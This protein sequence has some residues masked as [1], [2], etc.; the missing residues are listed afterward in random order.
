MDKM[1]TCFF[2]GHRKIADNKI[3]DIKKKLTDNIET[4]ITNQDIENFISG[5]ALGFDTMAAEAVIEL[6]SKY[7]HIKLIIYVPCYGQSSKWTS[8]QK[9]R[10]RTI[11][12][13]ADKIVY[14]TEEGYTENCMRLR[15]IRMVKDSFFCIAF[16]I[17]SKTGTGQTL[18][19]ANAEGM[20]IINIADELYN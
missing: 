12:S 16:C 13:K 6:K 18:R 2:T 3:E 4:L 7:P 9:Y 11:L 5:G 10:Y 1:K 8:L 20:R 19:R 15:N 17:Y 14:I